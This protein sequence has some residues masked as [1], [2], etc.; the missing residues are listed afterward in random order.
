M[1]AKLNELVN[2]LGELKRPFILITEGD[3]DEIIIRVMGRRKYLSLIMA[4][5]MKNDD[6]HSIVSASM[7]IFSRCEAKLEKEV[8]IRE[9]KEDGKDV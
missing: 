2:S 1:N 8:K 9:R 3:D 7:E 6:V 5:A 4:I